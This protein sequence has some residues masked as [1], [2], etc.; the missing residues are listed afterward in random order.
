[1]GNVKKLFTRNKRISWGVI[2]LWS[3]S[4]ALALQLKKLLTPGNYPIGIDPSFDISVAAFLLILCLLGLLFIYYGIQEQ[5][6]QLDEKSGRFLNL[7]TYGMVGLLVLVFV[8]SGLLFSANLAFSHQNT[9]ISIDEPR[10]DYSYLTFPTPFDSRLTPTD[11]TNA[12]LLSGPI[13]STMDGLRVGDISFSVSSNYQTIYTITVYT[14]R[15]KCSLQTGGTITTYAV[16]ATK[17]LIRGPGQVTEDSF[18]IAQGVAS[19]HGILVSS[20]QAHGALYL[21][22]SDPA[23]N[24]SCDLGSF[25]FTASPVEE[26]Q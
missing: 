18:F 20:G 17:S 11:V 22:Y 5:Q 7:A 14:Y 24:R 12:V 6:N 19:I 23:S 9:S 16:D 8:T 25:T 13:L 4:I 21:N 15:I 10:P 1:M 3:G 2:L 26:T